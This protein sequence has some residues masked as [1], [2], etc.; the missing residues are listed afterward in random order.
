ML[1]IMFAKNTL[2]K[3]DALA[4]YLPE[5]DVKSSIYKKLNSKTSKALDKAIESS[6]FEAKL[7]Q[8][9]E[10]MAPHGLH[11]NRIV[12]V[13][14]G[15]VKKITEHILQEAGAKVA[16]KLLKSGE[17]TIQFMIEEIDGVKISE[18]EIATNIAF[19]AR[20]GSYTFLKYKT[21]KKKEVYPS[22]ER[23]VFLVSDIE[24]AE[25]RYKHFE[26]I[27]NG[28]SMTRDFVNEPPN[29]LTPKTYAK[30]IARLSYLGIDVEVIEKEELKKLGMNLLLAV[31]QGSTSDARLVIAKWNGD[32]KNDDYP[33]ALIGKGVTYDTGG[34]SLKRHDGLLNMKTDMAGSATVISTIKSLAL[35]N[36]KV[37]AIAVIAIVENSISANAYKPDDVIT[38]MSGKTVEIAHTDAEGRL[39]LADSITYTQKF[40]KPKVIIDV[41]T[42]TGAAVVTF[43]SEYAAILS[44]SDSLSKEFNNVSKATG[45][46]IWRLPL[47]KAFAKLLKSDIADINHLGTR[48]GQTINAAEF[49]HAFVDD[50]KTKWAH[51]DIAGTAYIDKPGTF[52]PKGATGY[53]V[54]LLN[55]Y[56]NTNYNKFKD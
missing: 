44:N 29:Y 40:Y 47:D 16:K 54:H 52:H 19:G 3:K 2:P 50:K 14:L 56:I 37:N 55:E 4:I 24:K 31:G 27:A 7:G 32:K 21:S 8:I 6:R 12:V 53:G 10:I 17:E 45:E 49:L 11:V 36:A 42:L 30:D 35:Q 1:E 43:G 5:G 23:A 38:S 15:K 25:K 51:L 20:I 39:A 22:L 26:A 9:I 18:T 28:I 34:L 13:G 41:A 48:E 33:I 46:K